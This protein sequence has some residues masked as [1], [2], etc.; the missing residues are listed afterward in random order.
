MIKKE[1][2]N[3][4]TSLSPQK[5][6]QFPKPVKKLQNNASQPPADSG[7]AF[8]LEGIERSQYLLDTKLDRLIAH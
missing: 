2:S 5:T 8:S 3:T 7:S 6:P 4:P 1:K